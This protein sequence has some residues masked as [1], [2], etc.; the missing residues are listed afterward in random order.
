[1]STQLN[2]LRLQVE[3]LDYDNKEG[4]ITIDI[5]KEQNQDAKNELEELKN[6]IA[7][8]KTTKKDASAE[9]KEKR[10]QE[11][12]AMMMAKFDTV[13]SF[14]L[15]CH[16]SFLASDLI[17]PLN[18]VLDD[19]QQGAFSEKDEQLRQ[20]LMKLD[21]IDAVGSLTAEDLT[22]VRRQLSEGQSLVRETVDRLRQSQE[23]NEMIT[24][25]RDE[26]EARVAA[27]ETEYEELL[28]GVFQFED[29]GRLADNFYFRDTE[30]TI[31]DEETSDVDIAES[32]TD[33]KVRI[34]IS[35]LGD[36]F[37]IPEV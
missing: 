25:R 36:I 13:G 19:V 27:L 26:L 29:D 20:I 28:G 24:R 1:M 12:M 15:P 34:V 30:K 4:V 18:F 10:K 22:A 21:S 2:E 17:L 8:M 23:E 6:H 7:D 35:V 33:L 31:N 5:L 14:L 3:R 32:M 9:D 16:Q 37:L 11:K